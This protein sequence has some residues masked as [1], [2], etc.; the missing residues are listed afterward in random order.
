MSHAALASLCTLQLAFALSWTVY[1]LFLPT[2]L[3]QAGIAKTWVVAILM[4]DQAIFAVMDWALGVKADHVA[5]VI[6]RLGTGLAILSAC[7]CVAFIALPFFGANNAPVLLGLIVVWSLSASVLRAPP[8]VLLARHA[9]LEAQP[10]IAAA[11]TF[12]IG[13]AAAI[14]PY[15]TLSLK[16]TDPRWPFLLAGLVTALA[17]MALVHL[18]LARSGQDG[19]RVR[20]NDAPGTGGFLLAALL[21][22]LG[23]Q[24]HFALNA[25]PRYLA[26]VKPGELPYWMPVFWIAFNLAIVPVLNVIERVE[27]MKVMGTGALMAALGAGV[28]AFAPS[29]AVL[30]IGELAAGA[31]WAACSLALVAVALKLG[32]R[33]REGSVAGRAFG[34]IAV[35][36]FLRLGFV[37]SGVALDNGSRALL[38][39]LAVLLW[40]AAATILFHTVLRIKVERDGAG[41]R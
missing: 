22:A 25:A 13:L 12:G 28:A 17:T 30:A 29:L 8:L 20:T 23:F 33:G 5:A 35:A 38:Q 24:I 18:P 3:E 11:F 14:S 26:F 36:I 40:A 9:N 16:G 27:P 41:I 4:L 21:L 2:L 19:P 1:V 39:Y 15:L 34:L 37:L 32:A 7:S 31:G 6:K 10:A